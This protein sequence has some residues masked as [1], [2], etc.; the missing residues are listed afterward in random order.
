LFDVLVLVLVPALVFDD[1][2]DVGIVLK[3]LI[4]IARRRRVS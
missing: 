2:L 1:A 3:T 4:A